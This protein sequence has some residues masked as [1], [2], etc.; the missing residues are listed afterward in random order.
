MAS[1]QPS[2]GAIA[3]ASLT[4][5]SSDL[6]NAI[7]NDPHDSF[8]AV[9][10]TS[11]LVALMEVASA[12]ILKPFL[13]PGQLSVGVSIEMSHTAATPPASVV[14]AEATFVQKDGKIYVFEVIA[15]DKGGIIGKA[16]H[17]R[18]IVDVRRIEEGAQKR[19]AD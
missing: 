10:A 13:E 1:L 11:R 16:V 9:F 14:E 3:S 19:A 8:P 18:A 6:A 2:P 12:R 7:Y 4:V 17:K 15:K 5:Q